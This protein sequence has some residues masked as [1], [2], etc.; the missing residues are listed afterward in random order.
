MLYRYI[1]I[2]LYYII[3]TIP[4]LSYTRTYTWYNSIIIGTYLNKKSLAF[5]YI[6][7]YPNILIDIY[8]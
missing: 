3:I 1:Y 4:N 2:Y 8:I 7:P 6:L 5:M